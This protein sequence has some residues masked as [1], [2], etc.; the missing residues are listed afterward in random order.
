MRAKALTI[1]ALRAQRLMRLVRGRSGAQR[2]ELPIELG[3]RARQLFLASVVLGVFQLA[4]E[5][6][7]RE[8]ERLRAAQLLRVLL[9]LPACAARTL[10]LALVHPFLNTILRVD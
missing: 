9:A 8:P 3:K 7:A 4:A 10:F 6:S 2:R 5:L 1:V